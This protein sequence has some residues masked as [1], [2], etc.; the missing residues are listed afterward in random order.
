M[1][2]KNLTT[3][4][5]GLEVSLLPSLS[6]PSLCDP[7]MSARKNSTSI[8]W[9]NSRTILSVFSSSVSCAPEIRRQLSRLYCSA[10][11][12]AVYICCILCC[13]CLFS[14]S[15]EVILELSPDRT[16]ETTE[17]TSSVTDCW[18][19]ACVIPATWVW[20]DSFMKL[21]FFWRSSS[22]KVSLRRR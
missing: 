3:I 13:S 1:S 17:L 5:R 16:L 2:H 20:K 10:L 6:L 11:S 18:R 8:L 12:A 21:A 14:F 9:A 4:S 22:R 7:S 15:S 19:D